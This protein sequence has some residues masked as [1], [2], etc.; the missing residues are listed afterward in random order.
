MV[1][2]L[3]VFSP[4]ATFI[5]ACTKVLLESANKQ[6][7]WCQLST[8]TQIVAQEF[9]PIA[10][11]RMTQE[12]SKRNKL[13]AHTEHEREAV[14]NESNYTFNGDDGSEK[15]SHSNRKI[16][17]RNFFAAVH[18]NKCNNANPYTSISK[19]HPNLSHLPWKANPFKSGSFIHNNGKILFNKLRGSIINSQ[20]AS[21]ALRFWNCREGKRQISMME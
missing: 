6:L 4:F 3:V 11:V 9:H 17:R 8:I 14:W 1:S 13:S 10:L 5:S 15:L 12:A 20:S 16:Q 7:K 18:G 2:L 21:P 19:L